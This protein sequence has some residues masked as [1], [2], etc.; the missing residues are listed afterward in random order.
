M[1]AASLRWISRVSASKPN[2][3]ISASFL[4]LIR[5]SP[6]KAVSKQAGTRGRGGLKQDSLIG[7]G[8][9]IAAR[10]AK[11]DTG[12]LLIGGFVSG[13]GSSKVILRLGGCRMTT[14]SKQVA[15]MRAGGQ[16]RDITC[17]EIMCNQI[18]IFNFTSLRHGLLDTWRIW[19]T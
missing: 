4:G 9:A 16:A 7:T 17:V 18:S 15:M 10:L 1:S 19:G 3:S 6:E 13:K 14:K 12:S 11:V 8:G 2:R 5:G